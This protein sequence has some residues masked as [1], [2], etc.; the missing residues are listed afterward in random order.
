[1]D[2][3]LS[4]SPRIRPGKGVFAYKAELGLELMA[5]SENCL[6]KV[7]SPCSLRLESAVPPGPRACDFVHFQGWEKDG[8]P[9]CQLAPALSNTV[10]LRGTL[11]HLETVLSTQD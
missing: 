8:L 2:T 11:G 3:V 4:L 6:S 10:S 5:V 7:N 9:I 1:M